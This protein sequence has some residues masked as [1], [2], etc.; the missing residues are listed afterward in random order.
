MLN[1]LHLKEQTD[2]IMDLKKKDFQNINPSILDNIDQITDA[3]EDK[4]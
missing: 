1:Q 3:I 2:C 4:I